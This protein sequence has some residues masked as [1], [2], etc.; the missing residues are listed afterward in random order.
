[1]L[2]KQSVKS[3]VILRCLAVHLMHVA[4]FGLLYLGTLK[5]CYCLWKD[6]ALLITEYAFTIASK[7]FA[8]PE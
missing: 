7:C 8:A 4:L 2:Q 5:Q 1:M 3:S 6:R